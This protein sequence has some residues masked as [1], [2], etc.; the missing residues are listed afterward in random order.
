[1]LSQEN[2][3]AVRE[4][5][6]LVQQALDEADDKTQEIIKLRFGDEM[7]TREIAQKLGMNHN[8]VKT[9]ILRFRNEVKWRREQKDKLAT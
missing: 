4:N 1:M 2:I 9:L 7:K 8:S 6:E 3:I 5:L